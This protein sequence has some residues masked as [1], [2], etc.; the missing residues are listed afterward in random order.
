MPSLCDLSGDLLCEVLGRVEGSSVPAA[1]SANRALKATVD[2]LVS[3]KQQCREAETE[4]GLSLAST[5][6]FVML[7]LTT[8]KRSCR[9]SFR[10]KHLCGVLECAPLCNFW[11]TLHERQKC[12]GF[13]Q[14]HR[15]LLLFGRLQCLQL[16]KFF[17]PQ[18]PLRLGPRDEMQANREMLHLACKRLGGARA[19]VSAFSICRVDHG[20]SS[21]W[22]D[23]ALMA[24]A[25]KLKMSRI[26]L[27][28]SLPNGEIDFSNAEVDP[29]RARLRWPEV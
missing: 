10:F 18:E 25:L 23:R 6:K 16:L 24:L 11:K 27:L 4:T 8:L 14:P 15:E 5:E 13:S 29:R 28:A 2:E 9:T 19:L 7:G 26:V 12:V 3:H 20:P 17:T 1:R 22:A 21:T